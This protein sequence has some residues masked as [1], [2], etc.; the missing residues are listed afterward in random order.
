MTLLA[1]RD[2]LALLPDLVDVYRERLLDHLQIVRAEVTSA[3]PLSQD[4]AAQLEK[5]LAEL[6]GRRVT[7]TANVDPAAH[8]RHR[9]PDRQ[10][11]VRRQRRDASGDNEAA[12]LQKT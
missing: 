4:R 3:V 9:D 2:R 1:D 12:T 8:R 6:T 11:G 5:R 10:H 7:M